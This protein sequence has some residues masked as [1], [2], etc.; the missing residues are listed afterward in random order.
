M[1]LELCTPLDTFHDLHL[2]AE[3]GKGSVKVTRQQLKGLLMDHTLMIQ[4]LKR[5]GVVCRDPNV[6]VKREKLID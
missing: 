2:A 5:H 3:S 4:E 6:N 1:A